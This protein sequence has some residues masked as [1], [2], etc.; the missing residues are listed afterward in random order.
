MPELKKIDSE[1]DSTNYDINNL[2]YQ[3][4]VDNAYCGT[5]HTKIYD[6]SFSWDRSLK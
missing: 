6:K 3:N 2:I 5:I 1:K 4:K